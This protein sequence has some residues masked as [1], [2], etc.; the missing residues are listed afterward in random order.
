L[1]TEAYVLVFSMNIFEMESMNDSPPEKYVPTKDETSRMERN[2]RKLLLDNL[3]SHVINH[4]FT[5][6][7]NETEPNQSSPDYILTYSKKLLSLGLFYLE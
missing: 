3:L 4:S 5:C 2:E 1:I 6:Q 7:F